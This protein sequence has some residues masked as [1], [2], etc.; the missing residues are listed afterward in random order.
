MASYHE[1]TIFEC[2]MIIG[3]F[4][5]NHGATDISKFL[6]ISRTTCQNVINNFHKKSLTD[7]ADHSGRPPILSSHEE[8]TLIHQARENRKD[9]LEEITEYFNKLNLTY[10]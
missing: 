4:K 10:I 6:E 2:G 7:V 1:L 5:D 3:L 9:S 8:R